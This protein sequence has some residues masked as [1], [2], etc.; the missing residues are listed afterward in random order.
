MADI[1]KLTA[2]IATAFFSKN[3]VPVGDVETAVGNIGAAL[4]GLGQPVPPPVTPRGH[5]RKDSIKCLLCGKD[6]R[7]LTRHLNET[8]QITPQEYREQFGLPVDFPL[9][10]PEYS[11][12]R[13]A[14]GLKRNQS[15]KLRR[16]T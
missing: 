11:A 9:I 16:A 6:F 5:V 10:C 15:R 2:R 7:T 12:E 4:A 8:H 13:R 14:T 1:T 3:I